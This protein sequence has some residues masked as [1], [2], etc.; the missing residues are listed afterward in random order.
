M[1]FKPVI[2][3]LCNSQEERAALFQSELM[4]TTIARINRLVDNGTFSFDFD[5]HTIIAGNHTIKLTEEIVSELRMAIISYQSIK[6]NLEPSTVPVNLGG[7][8]NTY[9][10]MK[11]GITKTIFFMLWGYLKQSTEE[12]SSRKEAI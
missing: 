3:L 1:M 2:D 10:S 5:T 9:L 11:N 8:N 7:T 6:N 12:E 4:D